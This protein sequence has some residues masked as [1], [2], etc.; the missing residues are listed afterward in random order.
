MYIIQYYYILYEQYAALQGSKLVTTVLCGLLFVLLCT[1]HY[2][3]VLWP[4]GKPF[5]SVSEQTCNTSYSAQLATSM[6]KA[7]LIFAAGKSLRH[8]IL[9]YARISPEAYL[10]P[11]FYIKS[12]T[13]IWRNRNKDIFSKSSVLGKF[14][15]YRQFKVHLHQRLLIRITLRNPPPTMPT[16]EQCH[17]KVESLLS[18]M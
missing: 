15:I 14:A 9:L 8:I 2:I 10:W 18:T 6:R 16:A 11:F 12:G 5:I 17:T 7:W 13:Y 3:I 1:I 4:R